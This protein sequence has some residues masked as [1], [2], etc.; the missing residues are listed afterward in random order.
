MLPLPLQT[1]PKMVW[2]LGSLAL[3]DFPS[4]SLFALVNLPL[5]ADRALR[6]GRRGGRAETLGD[7]DDSSLSSLEGR[8][9]FSE[10]CTSST[11][12]EYGWPC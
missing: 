2:T 3:N 4:A 8:T 7:D 6:D 1:L 9:L 12:D 5:D 11:N 10:N